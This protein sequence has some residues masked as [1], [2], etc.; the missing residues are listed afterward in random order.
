MGESE[1]V[2]LLC[3]AKALPWNL[4]INT[5]KGLILVALTAVAWAEID[6]DDE[7][8]ENVKLA[9]SQTS[10]SGMGQK[11][12]SGMTCATTCENGG[13]GCFDV[14]GAP[15]GAWDFCTNKCEAVGN[16]QEMNFDCVDKKTGGASKAMTCATTC[17]N[18]GFGCFDV[19]GAPEG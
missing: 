11:S 5:M 17:E 18:G 19:Q 15:E 6:R 8:V 10:G 3:E 2:P 1:K 12:G 7:W 13:F 4:T 14:Q 9:M 16:Q